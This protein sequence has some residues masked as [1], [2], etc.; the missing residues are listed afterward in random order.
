MRI[1]ALILG[2]FA[3][4]ILFFQSCTLGVL[5]GIDQS[6]SE[7]FGTET[8]VTEETQG[9]AGTGMLAA[10][11]GLVGSGLAISRSRAAAIVLGVSAF[12]AIIGGT[13]GGEFG[14]LTVWGVMYAIAAGLA[15]LGRRKNTN[16][17]SAS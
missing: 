14:D 3:S 15:F 1:A 7:N 16:E 2:L 11:I 5:G 8:V 9:Q 12:L 4:L 10:L 6:M 17:E 13:S